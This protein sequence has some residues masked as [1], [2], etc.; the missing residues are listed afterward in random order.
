MN[1]P[2]NKIHSILDLM[3]KVSV[4]DTFSIKTPKEVLSDVDYKLVKETY[5]IINKYRNN[6]WMS[7]IPESEIQNDIIYLQCTVVLLAEKVSQ[8][9][10]LQDSEEDKIKIQRSKVRLA[11]K[12]GKQDLEK[13]G[14]VKIT[15]DEIKDASLALTETL[16]SRYEDIKIGSNFIKYVFYAVKDMVQLLEKALTRM[17]RF[18]PEDEKRQEIGNDYRRP[19]FSVSGSGRD[20][21]SSE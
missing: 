1:Q 21:G 9:S 20:T 8:I 4:D 18:I 16:A 5:D 10:S 2:D 17:Y 15:N 14:L 11:L 3:D 6:T 19:K 13:T 7:E 12:Q